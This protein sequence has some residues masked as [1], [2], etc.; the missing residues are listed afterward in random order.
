MSDS[1]V[2]A[3]KAANL[4]AIGRVDEAVTLIGEAI[5]ADPAN[6]DLHVAMARA[7]NAQGDADATLAAAER[8]LALEV[9]VA[10]LHLAAVAHRSRREW[11]TSLELLARAV[12]IDPAAANL[13]VGTALTLLGPWIAAAETPDHA[14]ERVDDGRVAE[15]IHAADR[16]AALDP[17]LALVPYVRAFAAV[18]RDDLPAAATHLEAALRLDPEWSVAHLV[19]GRIRARQGMGRL[20][21]RHLAAAGRLEPTDTGALH[22]LR[23]LTSPVS[24][25]ARRKGRLD[26]ERVVPDARRILEADLRVGGGRR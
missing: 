18:A 21:S 9:D 2:A 13:H 7:H 5:A 3:E 12:E 24:R 17:E 4:L 22:L 14:A 15:A 6:P 23:R 20:A 1:T 26:L 19:L 16:A 25:R 10:A 11:T 8:A